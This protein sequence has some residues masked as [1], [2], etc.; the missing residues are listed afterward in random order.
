MVSFVRWAR[1]K[2]RERDDCLTEH[3]FVYAND[4]SFTD[5]IAFLDNNVR[6]RP[7]R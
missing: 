2:K 3:T 6:P 1:H 5:A 4:R 7:P